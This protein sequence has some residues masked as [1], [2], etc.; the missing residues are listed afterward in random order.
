MNDGMER[1]VKA[2]GQLDLAIAVV[3]PVV[4]A[5]VKL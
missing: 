3:G 4:G 2:D 1:E 5:L